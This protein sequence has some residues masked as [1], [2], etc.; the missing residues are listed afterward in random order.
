MN[1]APGPITVS[2]LR[3]DVGGVAQDFLVALMGAATSF[4]TAGILA[5]VDIRFGFSLYS[6]MFWFVIPAGAICCGFVAASGY[7]IGAR[8]FQHRPTKLLLAN[9]LGIAT[10]TFFL[11]HYL[12]YYFLTVDGKTV[13]DYI[14]FLDFL[15]IDLTH[16]SVQFRIK[17]QAIGSPVELGSWGY[18]YAALQITGFAIGGFAVYAYLLTLPYCGRCSKY[19]VK[20]EW[21]TRY[22]ADSEKLAQLAAAM[23]QRVVAGHPQE[24]IGLHAVHGDEKCQ[25]GLTLRSQVEI[26]RCKDCNQ[27]WMR[28]SVSRST[29]GEWKEIS[30]VAFYGFTDDPL[31]GAKSLVAG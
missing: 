16:Q 13:R 21:Q 28:F 31:V 12:S 2:V 29:N 23:R 5:A 15:I 30:G 11:I 4:L 17:A 6:F 10:T 1:T 24:A 22:T 9:I 18:L 14:S 7:C 3:S 19:L 25:E 26:K 8:L 20:K 27:H